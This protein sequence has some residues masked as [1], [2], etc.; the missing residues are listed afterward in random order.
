MEDM[1]FSSAFNVQLHVPALKEADIRT[2]LSSLNA[3][4]ATDVSR[5]CLLVSPSYCL[6]TSPLYLT[7]S[8][9]R[10]DLSLSLRQISL[11]KSVR[12]VLNCVLKCADRLSTLSLAEVFV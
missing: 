12:R 8:L 4:S 6:D 9:L 10:N 2:V 7:F 5:T 3:F 1:G 11:P